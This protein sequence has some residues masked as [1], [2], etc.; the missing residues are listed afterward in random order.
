MDLRTF[1]DMSITISIIVRVTMALFL[2]AANIP[3][4]IEL[5]FTARQCMTRAVMRPLVDT[6]SE[7]C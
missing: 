1:T 3:R 7:Y 2:R 5:N 6:N 4:I